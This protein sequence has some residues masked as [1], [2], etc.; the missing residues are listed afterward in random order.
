M[1]HQVIDS[2]GDTNVLSVYDALLDIF[3]RNP[4]Y[5]EDEKINSFIQN[6]AIKVGN[7]SALQDASPP[8]LQALLNIVKGK[9]G[10]EQKRL[11]LEYNG[12]FVQLMALCTNHDDIQI[13]ADA[14]DLYD[15]YLNLEELKDY[16]EFHLEQRQYLKDGIRNIDETD[17]AYVFVSKNPRTGG[18]DGLLLS[19]QNI[20]AML[21]P[22]GETDWVK[23]YY[24]ESAVVED[25][26]ITE[27]KFPDESELAN[28]FSKFP[29]FKPAIQAHLKN[30]GFPT[31][32][33]K[34]GLNFKNENNDPNL[35]PK[36][37]I[38]DF[39]QAPQKK[40]WM[41]DFTGAMDQARLKLILRPLLSTETYAPI[42]DQVEAEAKSI[43]DVH[44]TDLVAV[45]G[46][47]NST[48]S[49]QAARFLSLSVKFIK[50]SSSYYFGQENVSPVALREYAAGLMIKAYESDSG[51]FGQ[52]KA[53]QESN[54]TDW[55]QR[56]LGGNGAFTC[57][58]VLSR[59]VI[60]H[61]NSQENLKKALDLTMPGSMQ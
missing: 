50:L 58:A 40:Q 24:V 52:T 59:L 21:N 7:T 44:S 1:M 46:L 36:N 4:L 22:E 2:L 13:K 14:E 34:M 35:S 6:I 23:I 53:G 51:V 5:R 25:K 39:E 43:S 29:L 31:Q 30:D 28:V 37:Y 10:D 17:L 12:F 61:L 19:Q 38:P 45:Y 41:V 15:A 3:I 26:I 60:E 48:K 42:N 9:P 47:K 32:L 56:L 8:A 33:K 18:Y 16:K 54:F 49:E 20:K 27:A 57:T 11:M 55:M